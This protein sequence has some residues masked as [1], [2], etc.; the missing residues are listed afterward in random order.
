MTTAQKN[1]SKFRRTSKW[2]SFRSKLK[3]YYKSLD[4][5]T[6]KPLRAGWAAHHCCM[7]DEEY[8]NITVDRLVPLNRTSHKVI[9]YIWNYY[10]DD[11]AIIDRL[12]TILK[13]MEKLNNDT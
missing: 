3:Y 11:P 1:K 4:A 9:H 13:T 12:I 10:K 8:E 5:L 2:L 7:R 6:N